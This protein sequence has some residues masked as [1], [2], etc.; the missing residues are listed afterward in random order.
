MGPRARQ[1]APQMERLSGFLQQVF[2][3]L[4]RQAADTGATITANRSE[5]IKYNMAERGM[6]N[7]SIK[8][9]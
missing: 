2:A 9:S 3:H 7:D 4:A 5:R 1:P 8:K 6:I